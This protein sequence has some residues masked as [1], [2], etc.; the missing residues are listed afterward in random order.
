MVSGASSEPGSDP[1]PGEVSVDS[2]VQRPAQA[3]WPHN[4]TSADAQPHD[5]GTS[6]CCANTCQNTT[7]AEFLTRKDTA[8]INE[9]PHA[10][11]NTAKTA[12]EQAEK[13]IAQMLPFEARKTFLLGPPKPACCPERVKTAEGINK[14]RHADDPDIGIPSTLLPWLAGFLAMTKNKKLLPSFGQPARLIICASC[15]NCVI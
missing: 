5:S 13:A 1:S 7:R 10:L 15:G 14:M 9:A 11:P 6:E 3:I 2:A 8:N 4:S 12:L